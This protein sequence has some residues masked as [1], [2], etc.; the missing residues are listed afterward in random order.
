[1]KTALVLGANGQDGS[2]LCDILLEKGYAVHAATR[3]SSRDGAGRISH[4]VGRI[5]L[6]TFDL[7]DGGSISSLLH[8][9]SPEEVYNVAD[10]DHVGSSW[11]TPEYSIDV[12]AGGALRVLEAVR[13]FNAIRYEKLKQPTRLYQPA[14][15]TMFGDAP[16]P[17]N[18]ETLV[19][20]QSPYA[21]AKYAAYQL[22]RTYRKKYG[23][24][25]STAILYNHDSP[26][27]G[28][29]YLLGDLVR[30][31]LRIKHGLAETM[32]VKDMAAYVD[33]GFAGDYMEAVVKMMQLPESTDLVL[34]SGEVWQV[35]DIVHQIGQ[36]LGMDEWPPSRVQ[37]KTNWEKRE[38]WLQG[39]Y[40]KAAKLIG[41]APSASLTTL[42]QDIIN[43][44]S[45]EFE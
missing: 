32:E 27:R 33:I 6:H 37:T 17:Q 9:V 5:A 36:Q 38:T 10:Q 18:E 12:T 29:G 14:S 7:A 39:H 28:P 15:A 22:A 8:D 44:V 23:M 41:F 1:M 35:A 25:V 16:A 4:L 3:R 45:K 19:N 20:P 31:A 13:R 30:G 2:Y 42:L 24:F 34:A 21:V 40:G 43:E 26:R 11:E